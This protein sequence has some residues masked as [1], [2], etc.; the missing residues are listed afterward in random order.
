MICVFWSKW[1]VSCKSRM[2]IRDLSSN[3][4][5][6]S[7]RDPELLL[8]CP[9]NTWDGSPNGWYYFSYLLKDKFDQTSSL[10][11]IKAPPDYFNF[12]KFKFK[13]MGYF[14]CIWLDVPSLAQLLMLIYKPWL[15]LPRQVQYFWNR[16]PVLRKRCFRGIRV[17]CETLSHK[18]KTSARKLS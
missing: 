9:A 3:R 18:N 7:W 14:W 11:C 13:F 16:L 1:V 12:L 4:I 6:K 10:F 15:W 2:L 17:I 5:K 8:K